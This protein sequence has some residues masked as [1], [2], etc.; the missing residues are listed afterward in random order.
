MINIEY[1][2]A[3]SE[4]LEIL[5][6]IPEEDYHKIPK[7]K[8]A[9]FEHNANKEYYFNYNPEK[10]LN[11]QNVSKIAKGIIAILFRDYWAT[12]MQRDKIISKQQK[13]RMQL[14]RIKSENYCTDDI[15]RNKKQNNI[16]EETSIRTTSM[17][18]YKESLFKKI[19]N[20]IRHVFTR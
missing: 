11:E 13:D 10:T 9:F 6:Y 15:F 20:K 7:D 1:A 4:V 5:K 18:Q 3:Y 2:N 16:K 12:P 17:I 19:L 8:I 14:E